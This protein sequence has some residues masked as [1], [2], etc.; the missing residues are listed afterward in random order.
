[1]RGGFK[2]LMEKERVKHT[3]NHV[4]VHLIVLGEL[5][6]QD[7]FGQEIGRETSS[8]SIVTN[9]TCEIVIIPKDDVFRFATQET[10]AQVAAS[11]EKVQ[12]ASA[13][14]EYEKHVMWAEARR[15]IL[16]DSISDNF[17]V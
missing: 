16:L 4:E 13:L 12:L 8:A 1:M 6:E 2:G 3:Q 5:H 15:S 17:V 14:G 10:W 11:M 9:K 7:F